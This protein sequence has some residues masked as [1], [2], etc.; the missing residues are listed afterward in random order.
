[1]GDRGSVLIKEKNVGK[2]RNFELQLF[3]RTD[4]DWHIKL[5]L[6]SY[7]FMDDGGAGFPDGLSDC[8]LYTGPQPISGCKGVPKDQAYVANACAY[9]M[10]PGKYTGPHRDVK[11]INAMRG[12]VGLGRTTAT[13]LG[14]PGCS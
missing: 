7:M 13:D 11:I 10:S 12:W 9:T 14:I 1:M 2:H 3:Q 5:L 4:A 6:S 8:K